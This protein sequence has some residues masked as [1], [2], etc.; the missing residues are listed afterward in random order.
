M[1]RTGTAKWKRVRD[2]ALAN[3]L[4]AGLTRCPLCRTGLDWTR[5]RQPN[6]PE[7]DHVVPHSKGGLD[8]IENTRVICRLCNGRLGGALTKR[9]RPIVKPTELES[10]PIW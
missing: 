3:A 8:V 1:G 10:S 5:S 4:D 9:E 2:Q 6:S 7:V